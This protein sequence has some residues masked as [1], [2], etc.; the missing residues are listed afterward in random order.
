[1]AQKVRA[2]GQ[3][4]ERRRK[5]LVS[6]RFEQIGHAPPAPA[7]V[8]G[9]VDEHEGL[10][11]ALRW[12]IACAERGGGGAH[13]QFGSMPACLAS[14]DRSSVYLRIRVAISPVLLP[15]GMMPTSSS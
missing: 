14:R 11:C 8:P 5:H 3:S 2:V 12:R 13:D 6:L 9:A 4:G 7:A 15:T 10:A 1:P